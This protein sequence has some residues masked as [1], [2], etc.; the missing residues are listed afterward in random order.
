MFDRLISSLAALSLAFLVWLYARSRDQEVLDNVPIP[1]NIQ[2]APAQLDNHDLE[3]T[4]TSQVIASFA[5]P[6]SRMRELRGQL[7]RGEMTVLMTVTVPE[8]RQ[9]KTRF[10]DTV[11]VDAADLHP[12]AGVKAMIVEGRNRI[13]VTL[14]R[15]T[16]RRLPVRLDHDPEDRV[17][18][19]TIEPATVLV[20]GPQEILEKARSI[21]TQ[22]YGLP[23]RLEGTAAQEAVTSGLVSLVQELDGRPIRTTPSAVTVRI[24]YRPRQKTV[25]LTDVP[26]Q[27]LCPANFGLR[28]QWPQY[29]GPRTGKVSVRVAG[30]AEEVPTVIAY[31]DLTGRKFE[32][33]LYAD[34]PLRLQLAKGFQLAQDPPRSATF[35]LVATPSDHPEGPE[36]RGVRSP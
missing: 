7:Q 15:L 5:G 18:Q 8:D 20:R 9:E 12:P 22:P 25:E 6:P 35:Q 1:V 27:F 13:P 3:V 31:I 33:G 32:P 36:L 21:T 10:H 14:S 29:A 16:E 34:E 23:S 4:G 26:V 24:T 11:R 28:P 2:L 17:A 19:V 30:P